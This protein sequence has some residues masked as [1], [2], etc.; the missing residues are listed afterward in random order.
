MTKARG[1]LFV[2]AIFSEIYGIKSER[3]NCFDGKKSARTEYGRT[4]IADTGGLRAL[5]TALSAEFFGNDY[6]GRSAED[7]RAV[8]GADKGRDGYFL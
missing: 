5:G 1:E 2:Y 6:I 3:A 4:R 8:K 7:E